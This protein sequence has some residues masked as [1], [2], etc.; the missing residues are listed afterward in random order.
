[1]TGYQW[2]EGK[3]CAVVF[4]ADVDAESPFLWA[5]R[6]QAVR[7]LSELEQRRFGPRQGLDRILDLAR[8][9]GVRGS[10]FVP[11]LVAETY[12]DILPK[13]VEA[14]HEIALH[15]YYHERVEE[16]D[17]ATAARW[18]DK[19][20]DIFRRQVGVVPAGYR[21][22]AWE[23]TPGVLKALKDRGLGYDSSL[24]GFDH[25][26]SLDGLT[27][28]PVQWLVD[29]AVYF[30]FTGGGR[31]RQ[32]PVN[33]LQVLESWLLEWQAAREFGGLFMITVHPWISG[34]GQRI[35]MLRRLFE[36]IG[37]DPAIWWAT[38]AEVAD[39]HRR[40]P[41]AARFDMPAKLQELHL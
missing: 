12:P 36:A 11:G 24:M 15:G 22:P 34:R 40:S 14:G 32:A 10:F 30:R 28:V 6:N 8:A 2:P 17:D 29:D 39:W 37:R 26:Y 18:I 1:M 41:N 3:R 23:M 9:H 31:D 27:E 38:A 13:L 25:P 21:S 4:S 35:L 33:P 19:A 20:L 7:S 16:I 5:H